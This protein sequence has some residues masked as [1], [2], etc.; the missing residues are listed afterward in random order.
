VQVSERGAN[1]IADDILPLAQAMEK[2][3][4]KA[5]IT[6][7]AAKATRPLLNELKTLLYQF[8]GTVP[9]KLTLHFDG[10]GEADIEPHHDLKVRPCPE[11]CQRVQATFGRRSLS[12]QMQRP[13]AR[14]RKSEGGRDRS[15]Q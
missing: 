3:A 12:M 8:H 10:R 9:V 15:H 2:F 6:L 1:I 7:P 11:F 5:V 13:E 4:S 14:K